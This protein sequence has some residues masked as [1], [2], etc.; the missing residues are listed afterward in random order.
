MSNEQH[1]SLSLLYWGDIWREISWK[2]PVTTMELME[3]VVLLQHTFPSAVTPLIKVLMM[4]QG[5]SETTL[6]HVIEVWRIHF[7]Q[8]LRTWC[9]N[10]PDVLKME[11]AV[12]C[13][14]NTHREGEARGES[15]TSWRNEELEMHRPGPSQRRGD[16]H[17]RTAWHDKSTVHEW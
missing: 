5:V 7:W 16:P 3:R 17:I 15:S 9:I 13:R 12:G 14:D 8:L 2:F 10:C 6:N 1:N 11:C 4:S